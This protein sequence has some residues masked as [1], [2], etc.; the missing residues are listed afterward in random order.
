MVL[1]AVILMAAS[2]GADMC[3]FAVVHLA[4]IGLESA[5]DF[6]ASVLGVPVRRES[7]SVRTL[8]LALAF[9]LLGWLLSMAR[10]LEHSLPWGHRRV[11]ACLGHDWAKHE[12]PC[13]VA[14]DV[15]HLAQGVSD[16]FSASNPEIALHSRRSAASISVVV[17]VRS[18][19]PFS[20]CLRHMSATFRSKSFRFFR[21]AASHRAK[22]LLKITCILRNHPDDRARPSTG[23]SGWSSTSACVVICHS[24][25]SG[26][27]VLAS[28]CSW[29]CFWLRRCC[30]GTHASLVLSP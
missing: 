13:H 16:H 21:W 6:L 19:L 4:R 18:P 8:A 15:C 2:D 10:I 7:L 5:A 17:T 23:T 27:P 12:E 30:H 22:A 29:Y 25:L 20:G 11:S 14:A 1:G 24:L 26:R 3:E 9:W 28:V